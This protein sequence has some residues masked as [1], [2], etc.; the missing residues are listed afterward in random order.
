[1]F[2]KEIIGLFAALAILVV[3]SSC[4]S[5]SNRSDKVRSIGNTSEILVVL[6]NEQQWDGSI[7]K[8]IREYLGQEQYGLNQ[9]EPIFHVAHITQNSFSD[10]FKKHRNILVVEIDR[11]LEKAKIESS[12]DLWAKPQQIFK[13][14]AQSPGDFIKAFESNAELFL[15][16]YSKTERDR[17]LS[18]F[19]TSSNNKVSKKVKKNFGLKMTIPREFYNAKSEPGFMWIR[20]EVEKFSQ[21]IIVISEEYVDTAQFSHESIIS[22]I[23][24]NFQQYIPGPEDGTYMRIDEEYIVPKS[25]VNTDFITDYAIETRGLWKVEKEFMGGPFVSYTFIDNRNNQ[26]VTLLSYVYQPNKPK[27]DLLRQLEAI[28]YSTKFV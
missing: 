5:N 3:T 27:R 26:I 6:Q 22:R 21:G 7:G 4:E 23:N 9:P 13:I 28:M 2:R 16:K 17:I 12:V 19:R 10:L 14:V 24:R 15:A 1:M 20:K 8:V 25:F 11:K 18:V